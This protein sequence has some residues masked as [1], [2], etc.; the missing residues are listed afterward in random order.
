VT[1]FWKINYK[2]INQLSAAQLHQLL[3]TLLHLEC[4][5]YLIKEKTIEVSE[6]IDLPDVVKMAV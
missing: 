4:E 3:L 6:V 5:K 1:D 2:D